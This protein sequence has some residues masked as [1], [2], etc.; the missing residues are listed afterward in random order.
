MAK[1][2]ISR[3]AQVVQEVQ[4]GTER[5]TLGRHPQNNVVLEHVAVSGRHAT[6]AP[7]GDGVV[8]EDLDSTNGTFVNGRRIARAEL[9]D[10][11][12]ITIAK[13]SIEFRSGP[14]LVAAPAGPTLAPPRLASIEV[15]NGANAGKKLNLVKPVTTLGSPGVLVVIISR[16]ADGYAIAHVEGDGV[17]LVNKEALS[18]TPRLLAHGDLIELTGTVMLFSMHP[19]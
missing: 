12:K 2:I 18:K 6:L 11:D 4:L 13:F 19:A 14:P 15:Q 17:A 10:K 9:K 3:D 8:L 16:R 7:V 5:T 1:I